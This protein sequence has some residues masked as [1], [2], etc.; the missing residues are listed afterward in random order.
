VEYSL[1]ETFELLCGAQENAVNEACIANFM[2]RANQFMADM[3]ILFPYVPDVFRQLSEWAIQMAVVTSKFR[4][5][6]ED[7]LGREAV[8]QYIHVII[9]SEDVHRKNRI[10]RACC[11]RENKCGSIYAIWYSSVT[12]LL[13]HKLPNTLALA[14]SECCPAQ[15]QGVN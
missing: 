15:R 12:A 14:S 13:M 6:V 3:T 10:R 8:Y 9:D 2:E 5:R 11:L 4:Y 1:R 7:I